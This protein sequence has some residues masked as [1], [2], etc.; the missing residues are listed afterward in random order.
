MPTCYNKTCTPTLQP[1]EYGKLNNAVT[2]YSCSAQSRCSCNVGVRSEYD[3]IQF[4][5]YVLKKNKEFPTENV[6]KA[7]RGLSFDKNDP[8]YGRIGGR[9]AGVTWN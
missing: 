4:D 6:K 3:H 5:R 2:N 1:N 7:Q 8:R 9:P